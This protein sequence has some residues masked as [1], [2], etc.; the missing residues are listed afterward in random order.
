VTTDILL[1]CLWGGEGVDILVINYEI[2]TPSSKA[3]TLFNHKKIEVMV[4]KVT[5]NINVC[6]IVLCRLRPC[7]GPVLH[8]RKEMYKMAL[9]LLLNWNTWRHQSENIE[10]GGGRMSSYSNWELELAACLICWWLG[11]FSSTLPH[12]IRTIH[13]THNKKSWIVIRV[14]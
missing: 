2:C 13:I 8:L 9:E 5:H 4:L 6:L 12:R 7:D 1:K 11:G 14:R 10:A 3:S